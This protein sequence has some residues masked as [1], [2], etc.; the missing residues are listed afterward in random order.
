VDK[1]TMSVGLEARVPFLD[2]PLVEA[3]FRIPGSAKIRG[4]ITKYP[5]KRA[6]VGILPLQTL[7]KPKHGFSVPLD[8]WF[9]GPLKSFLRDT[10]L[11]PGAR[12]RDWLDPTVVSTL[13]EDH[14]SGVRKNGTALWILLNFEL[15]LRHN[16]T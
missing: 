12:T 14:F 16:L 3:A 2:H 5:L 8:E 1:A 4:T 10:V 6:M 9:S 13:C 7:V 11:A 15:W